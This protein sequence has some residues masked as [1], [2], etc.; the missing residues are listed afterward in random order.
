MQNSTGE[1]EVHRKR[2]WAKE[3]A[4]TVKIKCEQRLK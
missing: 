2:K 4:E 3:S 1:A